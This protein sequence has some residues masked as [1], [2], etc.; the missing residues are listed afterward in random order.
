[1]QVD[2]DLSTEG[3][4]RKVSRLQAHLSMSPVACFQLKNVGRRTLLVNNRQVDQGQVA[5]LGH[6]SLVEVGGVRLLFMV[7][8]AATERA[9]ARTL[10]N[11]KMTQSLQI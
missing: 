2:I 6:L 1:L 10:C 8:H 5:Q 9:T 11:I 3:D 4:A 7:N